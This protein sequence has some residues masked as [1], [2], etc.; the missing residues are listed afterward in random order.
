MDCNRDA[1]LSVARDLEELGLHGT[2][3]S[4]G[5]AYAFALRLFEAV[6]ER[7]R[8]ISESIWKRFREA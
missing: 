7:P 4:D 2:Y 8:W 3:L 6:G 1:V 5:V